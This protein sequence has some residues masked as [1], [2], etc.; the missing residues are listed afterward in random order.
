MIQEYLVE[1]L[2]DIFDLSIKIE[3]LSCGYFCE[4]GIENV[5]YKIET[6]TIGELLGQIIDIC[7]QYEL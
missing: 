5:L 1:T 7:L 4:I 3:E 2:E 6:K